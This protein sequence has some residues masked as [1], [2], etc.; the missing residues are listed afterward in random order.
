MN[1]KRWT[2][3]ERMRLPDY[4]FGNRQIISVYL[5]NANVG[6][7]KW[8]ISEIGLPDPCCIWN[9]QFGSYPSTSGTGYLRVGLAD[10]VP[11]SEAE[12]NE[13][14]ELFPNYGDAWK[15]PNAITLRSGNFA[16]WTFDIRKGLATASKKI[17]M[18]VQC[19]DRIMRCF[20]A[21]VVSGLPTNISG[22]LA[23]SF[24]AKVR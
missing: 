20:F 15:T 23:H 5:G 19:T 1:L 17:V 8:T 11:T 16:F 13:A 14:V 3:D 10:A 2:I 6:T 4:C 22:F 21:I 24:L 7:F 12:M 18:E 9:A